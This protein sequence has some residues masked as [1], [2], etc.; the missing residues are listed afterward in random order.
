M[1]K[2]AGV[3]KVMGRRAVNDLLCI[4]GLVF[5]CFILFHGSQQIQSFSEKRFLLS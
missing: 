5:P 4:R 3:E 1:V 2:E